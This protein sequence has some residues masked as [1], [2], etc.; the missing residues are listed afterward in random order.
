MIP[1]A[2]HV[3]QSVHAGVFAARAALTARGRNMREWDVR[4]V[5]HECRMQ[6]HLSSR[7]L[8]VCPECGVISATRLC[9]LHSPQNGAMSKNRPSGPMRQ[10]ST[11]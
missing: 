8:A 11:C 10:S 2:L 5:L 9:P 3:L 7:P 4:H 6:V 1:S